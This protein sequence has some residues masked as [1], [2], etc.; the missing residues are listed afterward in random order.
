MNE[1]LNFRRLSDRI[2]TAGQPTR[3]QF[4]S[5]RDAGCALVV[6]L[7]MP[8]SDGFLPDEREIVESSGIRYV[9]IPIV[10]DAPQIEDA[11]QLFGLL[12]EFR[13]HRVFV[14]CAKNMRVSA[15]MW[16]YCALFDGINE[17][18]ARCTM[19][20]IWTPNEIW[21]KYIDDVRADFTPSP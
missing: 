8:E 19:H 4:S 18:T 10:W 20:E 3:E 7:A 21:Q 12:Q 2:L 5:I 6:N 11:Q 16:V 14:H 17:D 15:L 1:I 13:T 9:A